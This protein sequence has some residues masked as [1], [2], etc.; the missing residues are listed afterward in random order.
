MLNWFGSQ[1]C[2]ESWECQGARMC[3]GGS[4]DLGW[5]YGDSDCPMLGPLDYHNENGDVVF[6]NKH[7][8]AYDVNKNSF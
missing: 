2:K 5:C 3:E 4:K 6:A 7:Y 1:R 8:K